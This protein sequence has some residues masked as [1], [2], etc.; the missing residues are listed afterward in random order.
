MYIEN[1]DLLYLNA[2]LL[3]MAISRAILDQN[4]IAYNLL[5]LRYKELAEGF[6]KLTV[7]WRV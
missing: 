5:A 6:Q 7:D 1:F 3:E 2:L 4:F